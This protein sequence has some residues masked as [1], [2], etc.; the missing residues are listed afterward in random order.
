MLNKLFNKNNRIWLIIIVVFTI[1]LLRNIDPFSTTLDAVLSNQSVLQQTIDDNQQTIQKQFND[2]FEVDGDTLKVKTKNI[3]IPDGIQTNTIK[4]GKS[5][6]NQEYLN[7]AKST[8]N[9][10]GNAINGDGSTH[11]LWEGGWHNLSGDG[12]ANAW[13]NDKWDM[14]YVN[15]GWK[16]EFAEHEE[17]RGKIKWAQ[18]KHDWLPYKFDLNW[19]DD[20]ADKHGGE[21][22]PDRG[23]TT[24]YR[25]T[26]VGV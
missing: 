26:W 16:I 3:S 11:L 17:G 4:L 23:N 5:T 9:L 14:I 1:C 19:D 12:H 7:K 18:N 13:A 21:D 20:V 15:R 6:L 22:K 8:G 2:L 24:S 10:A 25:A